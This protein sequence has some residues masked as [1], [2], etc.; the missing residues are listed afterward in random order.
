MVATGVFAGGSSL[1]RCVHAMVTDITDHMQ[2]GVGKFFG[3]RLIDFG[4]FAADGKL[5][6]LLAFA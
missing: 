2:Q 1:F 3:N 4:I 5:N 6:L